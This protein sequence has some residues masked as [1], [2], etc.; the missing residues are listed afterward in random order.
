MPSVFFSLAADTIFIA[1]VIFCVEA[2]ETILARISF[3]DAI[4]FFFVAGLT[5]SR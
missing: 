3:S 1:L 5:F 2:T 4:V